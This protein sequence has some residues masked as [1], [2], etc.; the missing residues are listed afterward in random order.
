GNGR[1][2]TPEGEPVG[3]SI[4]RVAPQLYTGD[5]KS[6]GPSNPLDEQTSLRHSG[7]FAA[8]PEDYEFEWRYA[9]PQDGVQPPV[10]SYSMVTVLGG[11][12]AQQWFLTANPPAPLPAS[13][14]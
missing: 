10:Y 11:P 4:I 1:A 9:P 5:L 8:H 14:P 3:V 6:L 2:F 13:Y 7:D 12:G